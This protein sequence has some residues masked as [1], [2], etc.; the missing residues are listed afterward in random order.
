MTMTPESVRNKQ[1]TTVRLR[2]AYD[3]GEVDLFLDQVE[4]ELERLIAEN[5]SLR[6][7]IDA[8]QENGPS[9]EAAPAAAG[10]A[11]EDKPA[12]SPAVQSVAQ[13]STA[14]A[15]ILEKAA[16]SADEIVDEA[17]E[18]ADKLSADSKAEA[19]AL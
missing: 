4:H 8:L 11:V 7:R 19:L 13:A 15:K 17:K 2:E 18:Q 6:S 5:D 12:P 9:T 1:F 10:P 14:A 16:V 3:M